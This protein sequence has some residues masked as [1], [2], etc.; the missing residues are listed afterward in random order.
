MIRIQAM[1]S[2][3]QTLADR[4]LKFQVNTQEL[5][6]E[7]KAELFNL[8]QQLGWLYFNPQPIKEEE[9]TDEPI[10]TDGKLIKSPSSRF[11]AVIAV[12]LKKYGEA[13]GKTITQTQINHYY[14]QEMEKHIDEI[15]RKINELN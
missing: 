15:K 3:F 10:V 1:L 2:R 5:P 11:R 6:S 8:E 14:E 9:L 13:A 4:T 12:Y 7:T